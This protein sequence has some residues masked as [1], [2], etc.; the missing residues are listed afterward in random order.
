[1]SLEVPF[2]SLALHIAFKCRLFVPRSALSIFNAAYCF[3][4]WAVCPSKCS[5]GLQHQILLSSV[6]C[7][8]LEVLSRS[9]VPH[10][11]FEC[12][13]LAPRNISRSSASLITLECKPFCP[14]EYSFGFQCHMCCIRVHVNLSF[15]DSRN[16]VAIILFGCHMS[17]TKVSPQLATLIGP[18][19]VA[20]AP[21]RENF[22]AYGVK[23][24]ANASVECH[25]FTVLRVEK[26]NTVR[27][28][29]TS[30]H[31]GLSLGTR[32]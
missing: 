8:S 26:T 30:V 13:L 6:G 22:H 32:T 31:A 16:M 21:C 27:I 10:I 2:R 7:L 25:A 29:V 19:Y 11:T 3:R 24:Y 12:G 4:L 28:E 1:L 23:K 20:N 14:S 15:K 9:S 5:L 18:V 17:N